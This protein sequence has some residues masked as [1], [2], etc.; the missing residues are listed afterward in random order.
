MTY[1]QAL[2]VICH[3]QTTRRVIHKLLLN[4]TQPGDQ[5]Q[6]VAKG[7]PCSELF[8]AQGAQFEQV[9]GRQVQ[10]RRH[11]RRRFDLPR[12]EYRAQAFILL[13]VHGHSASCRRSLRGTTTDGVCVP[14]RG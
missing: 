11:H 7:M 13:Y 4:A 1:A 5:T 8:E 14:R 6:V 12:F 9:G 2:S 3:W 10:K